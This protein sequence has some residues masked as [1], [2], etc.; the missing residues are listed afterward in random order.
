MK[1]TGRDYHAVIIIK[2]YGQLTVL[3]TSKSES[4]PSPTQTGR[5]SQDRLTDREQKEQ[6]DRQ[7]ERQQRAER[8]RDKDK[9]TETR[10]T[11]E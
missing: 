3:H 7:T 9:K 8:Q 4:S 11:A 6:T 2:K 5:D 10:E 1:H